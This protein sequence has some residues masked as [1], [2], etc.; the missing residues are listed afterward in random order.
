MTL[1]IISKGGVNGTIE[2][3][4]A[5]KTFGLVDMSA[6]A[7][8]TQQAVDMTKEIGKIINDIQK[9]EIDN[10]YVAQMNS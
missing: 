2:V 3:N 9:I 7:T 10:E 6:Q 1:K 5:I 4:N 8:A